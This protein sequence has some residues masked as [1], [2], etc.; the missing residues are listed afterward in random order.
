M[1]LNHQ[2]IGQTVQKVPQ[3]SVVSY[4]QVADLAGLP[5]KARL[6]GKALGCIPKDGW[7]GQQVP[8]HR[9]IN[10]QGKISLPVESEGY[11]NQR[12]L[13]LS[14]GVIVLG[15]KIKMSTYQ[16]QPHISELLFLFDDAIP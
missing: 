7:Q 13:L 5:G 11:K 14:E 16:W 6:V 8:W 10:S 3:G 15:N 9:V 12:E 2:K 4:G 1:S